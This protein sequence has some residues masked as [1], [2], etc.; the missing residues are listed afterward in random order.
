VRSSL[1]ASLAP[2]FCDLFDKAT[3]TL[4]E[5][6]CTVTQLA[7]RIGMGRLADYARLI[8]PLRRRTAVY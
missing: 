1:I 4:Y 5:S 7:T 3:N 8:E 2:L 6:K